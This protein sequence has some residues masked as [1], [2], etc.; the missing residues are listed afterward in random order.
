M[1]MMMTTITQ[2]NKD[3]I[4]YVYIFKNLRLPN[5]VDKFFKALF[6]F[7]FTVNAFYTARPVVTPVNLTYVSSCIFSLCEYKIIFMLS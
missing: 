7:Q 5:S 6:H 1:M 4:K 3:N 2:Y